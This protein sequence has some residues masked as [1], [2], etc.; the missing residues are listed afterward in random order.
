M[1]PDDTLSDKAY[2]SGF[3]FPVK[4]AAASDKLQAWELGGVGLNDPSEG[5]MVKLWKGTLEIDKDTNV[6]Y[7]YVQAPGVP[8]T[9]LFSGVGISEIDIAFDQNMNP[10][11]AYMQGGDAKIW[12]YDPTVPGMV[13]TTLPA[14][15]YDLRCTLDDKRQF[16]VGDSDI[17]LS[18]LRSGTL[19]V[20]YQRERYDTEHVLRAG[21]GANA[22]LVSMAMNRGSRMQ[23]RLRNY[24]LTSDPGALVQADPF[25]A[26]VVA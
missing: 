6:G 22:R 2:P 5:L 4:S 18:Y 8:K 20:R 11:V 12:W 19:Y 16:N 7:V 15:S 13:H 21:I 17:I 26:D 14:G 23:W 9:L 1:L 3:N 24:A 10:F 25:L